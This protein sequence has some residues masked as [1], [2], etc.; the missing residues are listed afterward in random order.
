M[1][2]HHSAGGG[3]FAVRPFFLFNLR[4]RILLVISGWLS[5]AAAHYAI[6]ARD[7]PPG[8]ICEWMSSVCSSED[9]LIGDH[10][11]QGR[12]T[13]CTEIQAD[14]KCL[15]RYYINCSWEI[16]PVTQPRDIEWKRQAWERERGEGNIKRS[17]HTGMKSQNT[18]WRLACDENTR[19]DAIKRDAKLKSK[20]R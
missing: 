12:T 20:I 5:K 6:S 3:E 8:K 14:K 19:G 10:R 7:C 16:T 11:A 9:G 1:C 13:C 2:A 18:R 17:F 4:S 15:L